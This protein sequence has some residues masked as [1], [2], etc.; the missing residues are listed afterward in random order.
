MFNVAS[1]IPLCSKLRANLNELRIFNYDSHFM[2][3]FHHHFSTHLSPLIILFPV[4]QTPR[5]FCKLNRIT[6]IDSN[7]DKILMINLSPVSCNIGGMQN[8]SLD[9][10]LRSFQLNIELSKL[11][12]VYKATKDIVNSFETL[13]RCLYFETIK[14]LSYSRIFCEIIRQRSILAKF[15]RKVNSTVLKIYI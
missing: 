15:R 9:Y 13:I 11:F 8:F 2:T 1:S 4:H 7:I 14:L 3:A 12:L 5:F 6:V 10:M